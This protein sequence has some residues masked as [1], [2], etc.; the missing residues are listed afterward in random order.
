MGVKR[1]S[2]KTNLGGRSKIVKI[3]VNPKGR[4]FSENQSQAISYNGNEFPLLKNLRPQKIQKAI[5]SG[6]AEDVDIEE[7]KTWQN[8]N[9]QQVQVGRV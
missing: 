7:S 2:R 8:Q 4:I 9:C 6:N 3:W 5:S 1:I